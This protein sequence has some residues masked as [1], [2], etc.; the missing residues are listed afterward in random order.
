MLFHQRDAIRGRVARQRRLGKMRIG[1]E[2]I[3]RLAVEVGEIAAPA[4]GDKNFLPQTFGQLENRDPTS[5]PARF[6]GAHQARCA[7]TEN[8]CVE[9]M[10]HG[11][12][13]IKQAEAGKTV[14]FQKA[15]VDILL[16]QLV[17]LY[18]GHFP[19]VGSKI[20][21]SFGANRDDF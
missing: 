1:G 10:D 2:E 16:L 19:T 5:A 6:D 21:V 8:Q 7:T 20:A 3:F 11:K 18:P 9:G 17:D 14:L 13:H 12:S 4:A 15:L